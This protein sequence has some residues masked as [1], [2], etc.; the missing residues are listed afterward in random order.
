LLPIRPLRLSNDL[1]GDEV[2]VGEQR[3]CVVVEIE[4]D[5][6]DAGQ[7]DLYAGPTCGVSDP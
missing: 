7:S 6:S 4:Q 5:G 3:P 2:E 1:G